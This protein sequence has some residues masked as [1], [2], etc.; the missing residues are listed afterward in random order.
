MNEEMR[1]V[2]VVEFCEALT[3]RI[4]TAIAVLGSYAPG[5]NAEFHKLDNN[6][7]RLQ[8]TK[9]DKFEWL[10]KYTLDNGDAHKVEV[11]DLSE[12]ERYATEK[13][14]NYVFQ[15]DALL[16]NGDIHFTKCEIDHHPSGLS[17]GVNE[18]LH[19]SLKENM[20]WSTFE[21]IL[22]EKMRW[23]TQVYRKE[24]NPA[25]KIQRGFDRDLLLS[26]VAVE[27]SGPDKL[28]WKFTWNDGSIYTDTQQIGD[29]LNDHIYNAITSSLCDG[30]RSA[31]WRM[32]YLKQ[33]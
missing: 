28:I 13:F 6:I 17:T 30:E 33:S 26:G 20:T 19:R 27:L 25:A 12:A 4:R 9:V 15:T 24:W 16:V 23:Y 32:T 31:P 14:H 18:F 11:L 7:I 3:K 5:H 22:T 8:V 2:K 10:H 29:E 1:Q 21:K